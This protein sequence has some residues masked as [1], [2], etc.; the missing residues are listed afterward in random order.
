MCNDIPADYETG[1]ATT[2]FGPHRRGLV[3]TPAYNEVA[4]I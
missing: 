3:I 2:A 4:V 1:S